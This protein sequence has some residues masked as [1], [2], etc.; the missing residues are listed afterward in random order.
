MDKNTL[1]RK[2]LEDCYDGPPSPDE[3]VS[4]AATEIPS[5]SEKTPVKKEDHSIEG[6]ITTVTPENVIS[7]TSITSN[8]N[9]KEE[10]V[11]THSVVA[12]IEQ[13]KGEKRLFM[14]KIFC[15]DTKVEKEEAITK[16]MNNLLSYCQV[17][18]DPMRQ[19]V[20]REIFD[21]DVMS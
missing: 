5:S 1:K 2:S 10:E 20:S 7:E 6:P 15:K 9:L 19:Q 16:R 3:Y 18:D 12:S 8:A 14:A 13:K 4:T 17:H 21:S 11:S